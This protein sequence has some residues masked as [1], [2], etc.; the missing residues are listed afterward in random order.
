MTRAVGRS[1]DDCGV[2]RS[3]LITPLRAIADWVPLLARREMI[4]ESSA[5]FRI[6]AAAPH[7]GPD[8]HVLRIRD[9]YADQPPTEHA[10]AD[11]HARPT[12]RRRRQPTPHQTATPD[13]HA[14]PSCDMLGNKRDEN[15]FMSSS[16]NDKVTAP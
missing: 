1:R 7:P 11:R 10:N 15:L 3:S 16:A 9:G 8:R 2:V 14:T 6:R 4:V 13:Q 12:R 5:R